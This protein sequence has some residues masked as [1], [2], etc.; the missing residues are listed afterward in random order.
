[1][2]RYLFSFIFLFFVLISGASAGSM[3]TKTT[4]KITEDQWSLFSDANRAPW[5]YNVWKKDFRQFTWEEFRR[6]VAKKNSLENTDRRFARIGSGSCPKGIW[7]P[8]VSRSSAVKPSSAHKVVIL[9]T[10]I[11]EEASLS[12]ETSISE[13]KSVT[14]AVS[15]LPNF[16]PL[17][18]GLE[19]LGAALMLRAK[20]E[21]EF[22]QQGVTI[23]NLLE[24]QRE[25]EETNG[26]LRLQVEKSGVNK[27]GSLIAIG[28]AI[29]LGVALIVLLSVRWT[30]LIFLRKAL[31]RKRRKSS[32]G[33]SV[34]RIYNLCR[35]LRQLEHR[36]IQLEGEICDLRSFAELLDGITIPFVLPSLFIR[37]LGG[38]SL[39][40]TSIPLL[41]GREPGK[42]IIPG[43][44]DREFSPQE[45]L[46]VFRFDRLARRYLEALNIVPVV[47]HLTSDEVGEGAAIVAVPVTVN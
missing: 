47:P 25:L 38:Q 26:T 46:D 2:F 4:K 41:Q 7:L 30:G 31:T 27:S 14:V 5:A 6:V 20:R 9:R 43:I 45:V 22:R 39:E 28:I 23:Q 21:Q 8:V 17:M 18:S 32:P 13:A 1:M 29:G 36:N 35:E 15:P 44:R 37:G 3:T 42:L 12:P 33:S 34:Y 24:R 16:A 11:I 40:D 10:D 19:K